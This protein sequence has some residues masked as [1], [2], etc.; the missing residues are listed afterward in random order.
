MKKSTADKKRNLIKC[1]LEE[2]T[3]GQIMKFTM[4]FGSWQSIDEKKIPAAIRLCTRTVESNFN[5]KL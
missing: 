5:G 2:C 1:L 4:L 3:Q